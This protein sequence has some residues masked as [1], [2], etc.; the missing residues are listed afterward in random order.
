[1]SN[2]IFTGSC[3]WS[4]FTGDVNLTWNKGRHAMKYGFTYYHFLLNHFQP[5]SGGGV[6]SPRGGFMF[7]GG[8]TSNSATVI[9]AY[10]AMAD[11]LIG[12]PN[13]GTGIAVAKETQLTNPNSLRWSEYHRSSP[14]SPRASLPFP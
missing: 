14:T 5:T 1:L 3:E 6:S 11:F 12:L 9:T 4:G 7:E 10:N 8:I 13:N 2:V